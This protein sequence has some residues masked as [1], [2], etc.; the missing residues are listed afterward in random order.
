MKLFPILFA[1]LYHYT[2]TV[3][4]SVYF[5]RFKQTYIRVSLYYQKWNIWNIPYAREDEI[6]NDREEAE[7]IIDFIYDDIDIAE[8]FHQSSTRPLE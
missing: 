5:T 4:A 6:Y 7:L 2:L 8:T 3:T 1:I